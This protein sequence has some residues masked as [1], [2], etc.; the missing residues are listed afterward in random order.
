MIPVKREKKENTIFTDEINS[1]N[2]VVAIINDA[3]YIMSEKEYGSGIA[4]L[5]QISEISKCVGKYDTT[6]KSRNIKELVEEILIDYPNVN[7]Q[8]FN[9]FEWKEALRWL[10]ENTP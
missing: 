6:T 8:V 1:N 7:I 2:I 3:P 10:I 4:C 9:K 5:K